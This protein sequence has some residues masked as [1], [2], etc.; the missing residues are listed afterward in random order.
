MKH[1]ITYRTQ[2]D[3]TADDEIGEACAGPDQSQEESLTQQQFVQDCDI[4]VLAVRFGLTG[5]PLPVAPV[6]PSAYGDFSDVP[7]LRTALDIIH[8]AKTKF[9]EL[10]PKL[11]ERFQNQPANLWD[12]VN[13]PENA[14]ES[15]RLGLLVRAPNPNDKGPAPP[16]PQ[17]PPTEGVT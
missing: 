2:N 1:R 3:R 10:P 9:M 11:R 16:A 7:D 14:E 13:D 6:D 5:K 12:F 4:N 8:D 17:T 15:V